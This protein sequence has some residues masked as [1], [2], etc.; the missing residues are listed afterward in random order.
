M[1]RIESGVPGLDKMIEGGFP[2][3]SVV[4][5]GGEPG[6]GKSTFGMQSLFHEAKKGN[7]AVYLSSVSE[8]PWVMQSFLSEF[9]F[10]DQK[11]VDTKKLIFLDLG[12]KLNS[13]GGAV[14]KEIQKSVE[15]H[16]PKRIF[17]DPITAIQ[18]QGI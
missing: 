4:L 18:S 3:P 6:T 13:G 1:D 16:S 11:L 15:M 7:T 17:I 10:Y 12:E 5:L 2:Y 8:P 9:E 14:L